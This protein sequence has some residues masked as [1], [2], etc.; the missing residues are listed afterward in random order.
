MNI[1][2]YRKLDANKGWT[3]EFI[4]GVYEFLQ[5]AIS[6]EKF[7]LQAEK[8]RCLCN[9]CKCKVF[10]FLDQVDY[11][12]CEQGFMSNYYWW[13]NHSEEFPQFP[14]MVVE[15]SYYGSDE[16]QEKFNLYE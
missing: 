6:Q 9:K 1:P 13:T 8:I 10:K 12:L 11:D 16:Q 4:E 15:G 5:F 2:E 3:N 7:Q 14:L